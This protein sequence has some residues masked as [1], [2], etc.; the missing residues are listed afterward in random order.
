MPFPEGLQ[1]V[2]HGGH[3]LFLLPAPAGGAEQK[4]LYLLDGNAAMAALRPE[5]LAQ[6]PTISIVGIGYPGT[7]DFDPDRR[8]LD[9]TPMPP[10]DWDG[11]KRRATQRPH[12]GATAFFERLTGTILPFAENWL[13]LSAPHRAIWGHSYGGLFCL[14][15]LAE[16]LPSFDTMHAA[17]PSL[18]W[19]DGALERRLLAGEI[20]GSVNRLWLSMGGSEI[21]RTGEVMGSPE[22]L[23][24]L[25]QAL[26]RLPGLHCTVEIFRETSHGAAMARSL[27]HIVRSF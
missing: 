1:V 19:G 23:T 2:D 5:W 10:A 24:N 4:L 17:S 18:W 11:G 6:N 7:S 3:Q 22:R 15:A 16:G 12:G 20:A 21:S 25:R 14:H 9:Y 27:E 8:S 13:G 26:E